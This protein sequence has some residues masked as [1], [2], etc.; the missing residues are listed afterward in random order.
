MNCTR[1]FQYCVILALA[2]TLSACAM[3]SA[4]PVSPV[5]LTGQT[6]SASMPSAIPVPPTPQ[7]FPVTPTVTAA[8]EGSA[9]SGSEYGIKLISVTKSSEPVFLGFKNNSPQYRNP[10]TNHV[11]LKV[12]LD[13]YQNGK[14]LDGLQIGS[15][16]AKV[17]VVDSAGE[18]YSCDNIYLFVIENDGTSHTAQIFFD[19][20]EKSFGFK[21]RY[22]DLA[23]V[24]LGL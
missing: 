9:I 1:P 7:T 11:I 3:S 22:R 18:S 6:G 10:S 19:V 24:D 13:F 8:R 23:L 15:E 21:L 16:P 14:M 5:S 2:A 20:P 4:R 17:A 12:E